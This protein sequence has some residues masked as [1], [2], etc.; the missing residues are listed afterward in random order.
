MNV[1]DLHMPRLIEQRSFCTF[2]LL[3]QGGKAVL[4]WLRLFDTT[5]FYVTLII[6]T[7]IDIGSIAF[8]IVVILVY[9]GCALYMLQQ[10]SLFIDENSVIVPVFENF[11]FDSFL[12]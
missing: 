9:S 5:S 8:I 6:K 12:N 1:T 11:F 2:V 7:I 10:N 3:S 4:D